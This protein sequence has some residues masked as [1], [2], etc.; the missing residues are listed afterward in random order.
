[1]I[2]RESRDKKNV[3]RVV[4]TLAQYI[5]LWVNKV[6]DVNW[7]I[8]QAFIAMRAQG[9]AVTQPATGMGQGSMLWDRDTGSQV[10]GSRFSVQ[11]ANRYSP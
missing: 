2:E 11:F 3:E 8:K 1:M 6:D 10:F 4:M 7:E 9:S 5:P